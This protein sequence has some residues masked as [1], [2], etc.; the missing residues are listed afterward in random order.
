[1]RQ[2]MGRKK[3]TSLKGR[4]IELDETYLGRRDGTGRSTGKGKNAA[5]VFGMVERMG[6]V[7]LEKVQSTHKSEIYKIITEAVSKT[8]RIMTDEY[9]IY[10]NLIKEGYEKHQRIKHALKQ[11]V[12][13][14]VSTN[15]IEGVFSHLKRM[16]RGTHMWVSAKYLQL[17]CDE[18]AFRYNHRKQPG[19]MFD[20]FISSLE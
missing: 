19:R 10:T 1:L 17:Y 20:I 5:I 11:Y 15:T 14:E 8:S 3:K 4:T 18:A 7:I 13:G 12:H 9:P 6:S 2:L 16:I